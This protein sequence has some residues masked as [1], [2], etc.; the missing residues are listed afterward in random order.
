MPIRC[1]DCRNK[2]DTLNA[3][4]TYFRLP[5]DIDIG[6]KRRRSIK[7]CGF[8]LPSLNMIPLHNPL[9]FQSVLVTYLSNNRPQLENLNR[10]ELRMLS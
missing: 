9:P 1:A 4:R 8:Q 10:Y 5:T 6:I 3:H 7:K 2:D